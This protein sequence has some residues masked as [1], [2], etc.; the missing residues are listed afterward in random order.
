M[1][2]SGFAVRPARPADV[3][4]L[5]ALVREYKEQYG[6]ATCGA[7]DLLEEW[8]G[9]DLERDTLL[10]GLGV[11]TENATGAFALYERAGMAVVESS[12]VWERLSARC[13][14]AVAQSRD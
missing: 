9:T 5:V 14:V 4:A 6:V 11:D 7:A 3:P 8:A 2:P 10:V 12:D 13:A 1:I